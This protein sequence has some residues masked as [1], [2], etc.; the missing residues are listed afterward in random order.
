MRGIDGDRDLGRT[1]KDC[2]P[3]LALKLVEESGA[4]KPGC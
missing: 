4:F 2:S 3:P 1:M